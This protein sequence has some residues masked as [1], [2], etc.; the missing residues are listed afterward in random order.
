MSTLGQASSAFNYRGWA[1]TRRQITSQDSAGYSYEIMYEGLAHNVTSLASALIAKGAKITLD[2]GAGKSTLRALFA[3]DPGTFGDDPTT[4]DPSSSEVPTSVFELS[5]E[6]V[7]VSVFNHPFAIK[8]SA[9]YVNA[10]QYKAD[11][12]GAIKDGKDFPLNKDQFPFAVY[13][14]ENYLTRGIE[15]WESHRPVVTWNVSYTEAYNAR[16]TPNKIAYTSTVYTR[17]KLISLFGLPANF[18]LRVPS[19]PTSSELPLPPKCVWGWRWSGYHV[20]YDRQT[21]RISENYVFQFNAWPT[22]LYEIVE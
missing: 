12:E 19:D 6:P 3:Y 15:Y 1:L 7:Q 13:I 11:L 22:G 17:S 8:E 2:V 21:N 16:V 20:G 10:S 5:Y 9:N 18:S 4:G 14:W